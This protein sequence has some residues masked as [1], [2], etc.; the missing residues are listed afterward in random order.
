MQALATKCEEFGTFDGLNLIP[1]EVKSL[2]NVSENVRLPHVGWNSVSCQGSI[3]WLDLKEKF[4][5][6]S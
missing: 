4:L 2:R 6:C 3:I 1:G 5:F